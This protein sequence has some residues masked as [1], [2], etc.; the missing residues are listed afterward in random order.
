MEESKEAHSQS[1][2]DDVI[3]KLKTDSDAIKTLLKDKKISVHAEDAMGKT[4]LMNAAFYDN[5]E[6][7]QLC[8]NL[9][10][11]LSHK[12]KHGRATALE[13]AIKN[14][15]HHMH[16][17]L[18][19][20]EMKANIGER[21]KIL[22]TS[23]TKQNGIVDNILNEL[24]LIGEYSTKLFIPL[25]TETMIN[26]ISKKLVFS[27]DM[28]LLCWKHEQLKGDPMKSELWQAICKTCQQI[29]CSTDKRDWF[30]LKNNLVPSNVC[31]YTNKGKYLKCH[32][33]IRYLSCVISLFR[34]FY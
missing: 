3:A 4:L 33:A 10:S 11:D 12:S 6:I 26:I 1:F 9:G 8:I 25:L 34:C 22:S 2:W 13:T 28:L 17:L 19:L 21:I 32:V 24:S 16:Q 29:I 15:Q 23:I 30:W 27:D 20:S 5:Y 14:N 7:A 18:L 31:L